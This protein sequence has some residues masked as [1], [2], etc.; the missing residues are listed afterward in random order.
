MSDWHQK[1]DGALEPEELDSL[2]G[3]LVLDAEARQKIQAS[4]EALRQRVWDLEE[5]LFEAEQGEDL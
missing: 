2:L 5:H 4:H 3:E 1:T